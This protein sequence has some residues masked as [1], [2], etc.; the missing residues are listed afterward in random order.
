MV[1]LGAHMSIAGGLERALRRGGA[2]GCGVI[3]LFTGTAR[4]WSVK[5]IGPEQAAAFETARRETGIVRAVVH[6]G[7]L[8]NLGAPAARTWNGSIEML[9][10]ELRRA[11]AVRATDLVLHPG[12]HGGAGEAAGLER[13]A[14]GLDEALKRAGPARCRVAL[15]V[16]AGQGNA[17]GHRF[18]H[19]RDILGRVREPER[20]SV[21][22]DTCHAFAAGYDLRTAAGVAETLAA[23]DRV[24]GLDRLAVFHLNDSVKELGSR[25]DRHTHIGKGEIGREGFRALV[26]DARF[27]DRPMIL[28]TPKERPG[29]KADPDDGTLDRMNLAVL[30]K[31]RDG[32]RR[33]KKGLPH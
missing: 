15:E 28:E 7:Y 31:L 27:G 10:A 13:V 11:E 26:R 23:F 33:R 21:C 3:Q 20:F 24:I 29:A 5:E 6:A 17:L 8:I 25:V 12:S 18:E 4:G 9:A 16:T 19:L 2:A 14:R 1:N 22:F 32:G 30:R